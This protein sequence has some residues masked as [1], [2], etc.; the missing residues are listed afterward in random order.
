PDNVSQVSGVPME[1]MAPAMVLGSFQT[2]APIP[3]LI[4][5]V[6][7]PVEGHKELIGF[8]ETFLLEGPSPVLVRP[9]R[10]FSSPF[11]ELVL[12]GS[13]WRLRMS[14]VGMRGCGIFLSFVLDRGGPRS[15]GLPAKGLLVLASKVAF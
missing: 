13:F 6:S 1:E 11:F 8:G 2:Q 4:L 7:V 12:A 9:K 14:V 15:V 5:L 10:R 3:A